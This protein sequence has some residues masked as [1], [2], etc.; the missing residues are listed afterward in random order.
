[1]PKAGPEQA[2]VPGQ[3]GA[4][5]ARG[6]PRDSTSARKLLN[7]AVARFDLKEAVMESFVWYIKF[8]QIFDTDKLVRLSGM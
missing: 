6:V 4:S 2:G 5:A 1:M 7:P 8:A 3:P